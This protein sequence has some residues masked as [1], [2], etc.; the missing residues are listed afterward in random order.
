MDIVNAGMVGVYDDLDSELRERVEDVVL[1]RKGRRRGLVEIAERPGTVA[2]RLGAAAW[3]G[4]SEQPKTVDEISHALVPASTSS[5]RHGGRLAKI[6]RGRPAAARDR[7]P[8]MAG[9]N[10]VGDLFGQGK[11]FLPQVVKSARHEAGGRPPV[12]LHQCRRS[13]IEGGGEAK[14]GKIAIATVKGDVHD[15]GKN[16]V[17]VVL[18]CNNFEV[19]NMGVMVA[20]QDILAKASRR[21]RLIGLRLSRPASRRWHVAWRCSDD[22]FRIKK[23]PPDRRR[24][25]EPRPHGGQDRAALRPGR[26]CTRREPLGQR[27]RAVRRPRRRLRRRSRPTTE[28]RAHHANRSRSAG[29]AREARQQDEGRLG[30]LRRRRR[31]HRPARAQERTRPRSPRSSTG[32]RSSTWELAGPYPAIL[33][34]DRRQSAR[35]LLSDGKRMLRRVIEGA[36]A[37]TASSACTRRRPSATTTSRST[38]TNRER[39]ALHLARPARAERA[40]RGRWREAEPVP[41]RLHRAQLGQERPTSACSPSPPA[42]ASTEGAAV[43]RRPRRLQRDHA[44]GTADRLAEA[45]AE[46]CTSACAP[47]LAT[48]PTSR[49]TSPGRRRTLS[50]HPLRR[51]ATRAPTTPS[52]RSALDAERSA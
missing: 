3:R 50:R 5:S 47:T 38:A 29:L 23:I 52:A 42:S 22:F 6:G 24:D 2:R 28:W 34:D 10:I 45:F 21:R 14:A 18:Q 15:I 13:L 17:T 1:N 37:P 19:V 27:L 16:I 9:M 35:R 4:T 7:R 48:P 36:G 11:M 51:P 30:G 43:R 49:S 46:R 33:T 25:D 41:G 12:A 40:A 39:R 44:E 26:R 8:L 20:C 31:A 32:A